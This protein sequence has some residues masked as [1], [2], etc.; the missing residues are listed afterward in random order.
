MLLPYPFSFQGRARR[1]EWWLTNIGFGLLVAIAV[2]TANQLFAG[3]WRGWSEGGHVAT[4]SFAL[5]LISAVVLTWIQ[6]AVSYRR[7]HDLGDSGLPLAL[8]VGVA[9]AVNV[10]AGFAGEEWLAS[11]RASGA[12]FFLTGVWIVGALIS[13]YFFIRLAFFPG[14]PTANAYGAPN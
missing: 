10:A 8:L 1:G 2:G 3:D 13:L 11:V 12:A 6:L 4:V 9:T 5:E 7:A 14:Q